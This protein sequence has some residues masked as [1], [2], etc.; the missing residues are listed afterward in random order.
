MTLKQALREA[1]YHSKEVSSNGKSVVESMPNRKFTVCAYLSEN[2]HIV[3][4]FENGEE[5]ER[6]SS[7][8]DIPSYLNFI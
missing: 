7:I 3:A 2:E 4:R 1:K 5:V 6:F 8:S